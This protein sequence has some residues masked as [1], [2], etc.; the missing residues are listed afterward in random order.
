MSLLWEEQANQ[1]GVDINRVQVWVAFSDLF[2]DTDHT[3]KEL[4]ALAETIADS[5]FT[6]EELGHIIVREVGPTCLPNL[7][8]FPGGEWGHFQ[9]DWLIEKCLKRQKKHPFKSTGNPNK[10]LSI[11]AT[12]VFME[13]S[14]L[15][16][17]TARL[18]AARKSK[19]AG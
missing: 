7:W 9:P 1:H 14:C 18:R 3:E 12:F 17:R 10:E 8:Q 16:S 11:F 4:D 15:L 5:P 13:A 2:L 6:I 19:L